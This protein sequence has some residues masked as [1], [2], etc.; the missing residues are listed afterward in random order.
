[1]TMSQNGGFIL[2]GIKL[3]P[4]L[5]VNEMNE[6]DRKKIREQIGGRRG[7]NKT[8]KKRELEQG[9]GGSNKKAKTKD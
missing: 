3:D 8:Q 2:T 6:E 4:I 1:M 9:D 7:K 5:G